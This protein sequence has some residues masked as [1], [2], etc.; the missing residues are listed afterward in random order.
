MKSEFNNSEAKLKQLTNL[1][2]RI[3]EQITEMEITLKKDF[4][5]FKL[6]G[7]TMDV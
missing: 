7:S 1:L 5:S 6:D 4:S 3:P 2:Q